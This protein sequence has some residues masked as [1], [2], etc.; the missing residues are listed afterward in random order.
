LS[1]E[2]D[3]QELRRVLVQIAGETAGMLRDLACSDGR[4]SQRLAGETVLADVIAEDYIIEALRA[5]LGKIRVVTEEKGVVGEGSLTIVVD[6]LDGSKNYLNCIPW[7]SV[8]IAAV[9]TEATVAGGIA[10]A[11][12]P[13][14]YGETISFARGYGCWVGEKR[15]TPK[16]DPENFMFVYIDH[17]EAATIVARIVAELGG[18]YKIRSL[19]S[20][21]L[22]LAYLGLGRAT[23]FIDLRSKL[24]NVD[25]AAAYGVVRECGGVL[26]N[27][28]G[29]MLDVG[30][31]SVIRA[32]NIVA[33]RKASF[34]EKIGRALGWP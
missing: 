29:E 1:V 21:A 6:P 22:E 34:R 26:Y 31:S 15:A 2:L 16:D 18:G 8:S 33:A 9:P 11:V 7:A 19:G 13:I 17:P 27:D 32:G 25:I 4:L 10:G 30:V 14:F 12:A 20:A 23:L 24:R 5:E 28:K 3:P